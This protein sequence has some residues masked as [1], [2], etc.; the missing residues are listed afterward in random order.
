MLFNV[1][2]HA[3]VQEAG[4]RARRMGRCMGL[5]VSDR[6]RGFDPRELRETPGLG[7]F[8]IRER[9]ELL[10]GRMTIRSSKG[11][12]TTFHIVVPDGERPHQAAKF[13]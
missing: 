5:S 8:S 12:G 11:R 2:K 4:I 1:V 7:L 13:A 6:G 9:V 3:K 10:G